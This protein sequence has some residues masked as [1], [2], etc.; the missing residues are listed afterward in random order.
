VAVDNPL[1]PVL[2]QKLEA[3]A[4]QSMS[5]C[6]EIVSLFDTRNIDGKLWIVCSSEFPG[7][8]FQWHCKAFPR[9]SAQR[10]RHT[11]IVRAISPTLGLLSKDS[12]GGA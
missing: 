10:T 5:N 9:Q 3:D 4:W 1:D 8:F 7:R 12:H 2:V 11:V 6:D